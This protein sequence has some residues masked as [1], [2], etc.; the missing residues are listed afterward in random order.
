MKHKGSTAILPF[1]IL[2]ILIS[3]IKTCDVLGCAERQCSLVAN[4]QCC[5]QCKSGFYQN[6]TCE[7]ARCIYGCNKCT[8]SNLCLECMEGKYLDKD[9]THCLS[10]TENCSNCNESGCLQC[11]NGYRLDRSRSC[12]RILS[13][14][15]NSIGPILGYCIS[16]LLCIICIVISIIYQKYKSK[17]EN[18]NKISINSEAHHLV[19]K[20]RL[21]HLGIFKA[22][23]SKSSPKLLRP[24]ILNINSSEPNL[25]LQEV[26][27]N[28]A[29]SPVL[30]PPHYLG[31][32]KVYPDIM[33]TDLPLISDVRTQRPENTGDCNRPSIRQIPHSKM[34][35]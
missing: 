17:V 26:D 9:T 22:T 21:S 28:A 18:R 2:M 31:K 35:C 27:S 15:A 23:F 14:E 4:E 19:S 33:A 12:A 25:V 10:C 1:T 6:T 30:S 24:K 11:E 5:L 8:N 29:K 32:A 20:G 16:G 13:K 7:C 3:E 34:R